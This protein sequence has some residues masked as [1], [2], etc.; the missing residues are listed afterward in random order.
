MQPN[1]KFFLNLLKKRVGLAGVL[2]SSLLTTASEEVWLGWDDVWSVPWL[3]GQVFRFFIPWSRL[4]TDS[5]S[6]PQMTDLLGCPLDSTPASFS[7]NTVR[8]QN[9]LHSIWIRIEIQVSLSLNFW[10]LIS[11]LVYLQVGGALV[12]MHFFP[13]FFFLPKRWLELHMES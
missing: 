10:P 6:R 1:K 11:L 3:P 5:L 4:F 12:G 7:N 9:W 13:F 8:L 2:P